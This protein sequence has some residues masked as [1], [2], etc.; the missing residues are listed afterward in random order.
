MC[1]LVWKQSYPRIVE[2]RKSGT[3]DQQFG[4]MRGNRASSKCTGQTT[5]GGG[6]NANG[7]VQLTDSRGREQR[8]VNMQ[9]KGRKQKRDDKG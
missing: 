8:A 9:K 6:Q 3:D 4:L 5:G 2:N 1:S 7:R